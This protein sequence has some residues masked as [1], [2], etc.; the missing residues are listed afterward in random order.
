[1]GRWSV[2]LPP[3]TADP[4]HRLFLK[5][6][7]GKPPGSGAGKHDLSQTASE[8]DRARGA[9]RKRGF[10]QHDARRRPRA[11]DRVRRRSRIRRKPALPPSAPAA[12]GMNSGLGGSVWPRAYG[13]VMRDRGLLGERSRQAVLDDGLRARAFRWPP[14][15]LARVVLR[16]RIGLCRSPAASPVFVDS[17]GEVIGRAAGAAVA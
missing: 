15:R 4:R 7:A 1:M 10:A 13:R 8:A 17:L 14:L 2:G 9:P 6:A 3:V 11:R 5:S 16:A 12:R